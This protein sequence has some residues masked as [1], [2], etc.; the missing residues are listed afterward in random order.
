VTN[1]VRTWRGAR[2]ETPSEGEKQIS[3]YL[4]HRDRLVSATDFESITM[5]TPGV[6]IGRVE[7]IPAF[8]PELT[9]SEPGG[10][11]GSVTLMLIPRYDPKQPDA[12]MPDRLFLDTVCRYLDPRRLVTT[13]LFLRGPEYKQIWVS[14]GINVV[15]GAS[16]SVVREAV[17]RALLEYLAPLRA[18]SAGQLEETAVKLSSPEFAMMQKGWPLRR[19]VAA[20]ELLAV[21]SRAPGVLLV[22]DVLL[23]EGTSAASA[24]ISMSGLQ[25]PRVAGISVSVGAPQDLE[26]LRGQATA[27]PAGAAGTP[28]KVVPVPVIPTEC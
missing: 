7:V 26:Q 25:L 17:K 12:P 15:A 18:A 27:P 3:R 14:V 23:A 24:Q 28:K 21:A 8:T 5:R 19:P 4:Q 1:P 11:P 13:E 2:A 16:T 9:P 22:N 6:D 20:R 10:A